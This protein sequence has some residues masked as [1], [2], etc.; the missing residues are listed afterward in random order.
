MAKDE[1]IK[2][3]STPDASG[4]DLRGDNANADMTKV[5]IQRG[6]LR[7]LVRSSMG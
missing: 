2:Q 4:G 7:L 6:L 3:N 1:E 5:Q